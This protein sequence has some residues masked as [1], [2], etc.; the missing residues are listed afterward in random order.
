MRAGVG[1]TEGFHFPGAQDESFGKRQRK[2][3]GCVCPGFLHA[4]TPS[5]TLC[6]FLTWVPRGSTVQ[7]QRPRW[8]AGLTQ[9]ISATAHRSSRARLSGRRLARVRLLLALFCLSY[10]PPPPCFTNKPRRHSWR[11]SQSAPS[12]TEWQSLLW[13]L[14][15]PQS[16]EVCT[17]ELRAQGGQ[18]RVLA[19]GA[20]HWLFPARWC[21]WWSRSL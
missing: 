21:T 6:V 4:A 9:P 11:A 8:E 10:K 19:A 20:S 13:H 2:D 5:S 18:C 7:W 14:S 15:P 3:L 12:A 16:A 17:Q 1:G